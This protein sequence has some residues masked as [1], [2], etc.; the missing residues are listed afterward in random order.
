MRVL[1]DAT[2]YKLALHPLIYY[3]P[4]PLLKIVDKPLI[5]HIIEFL[6]KQGFQQVDLI[7]SHLP[8]LIEEAVGE[9]ERWGIKVTYHLAKEY[10]SPFLT[11]QSIC[12]KWKTKKVLLGQGDCF[13][14]FEKDFLSFQDSPHSQ[15]FVYPDKKWSGWGIFNLS[16]FLSI[17]KE[18]SEENFRTQ[19]GSDLQEE[20]VHPFLSTQTFKEV[21]TANFKFLTKEEIVNFFPA[22]SYQ[23]QPGIWLSRAVSILP[24]VTFEPPLFIGENCQ[25]KTGVH[26][27]PDVV[28][29]NNC[30]IDKDST[31]T[32]SV[33]LQHSYVGEGLNLQDSLVDR[34]LLINHA[35][36]TNLT[37]QDDFILS[38]LSQPS[39]FNYILTWFE[40]GLAALIFLLFLPF[41]LLMRIFYPTQEKLVIKLPAAENKELWQIFVW[42]SFVPKNPNKK[43]WFPYFFSSLPHFLSICQGNAHFIGVMP[44]SK[45]EIDSLNE[46]WRRFYLKSKVGLI[47]LS[48]L[49][50]PLAS[51]SDEI[52]AAEAFY[53]SHKGFKTDSTLFLR[54]LRQKL[55]SLFFLK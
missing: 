45:E 46:E 10:D 48:A 23:V 7:L 17:K 50:N 13:P 40:R 19:F 22:T 25:I 36:G 3:L 53:T 21:S 33:V 27:G 12:R 2:G 41:Y 18:N 38:E 24:G 47:T 11:I 49:N 42:S 51:T 32:T 37:I 44:R 14:L 28:I 16:T 43:K 39:I 35:H 20:S 9:G 30:V 26:L 29:E 6:V 15:F 52:Y 1:L 31:I 5:I 4:S 8:L 55:L 34:N 54:W